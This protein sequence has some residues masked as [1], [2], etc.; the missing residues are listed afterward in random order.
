MAFV[1]VVF[2]ITVDKAVPLTV[3]ASASRVPST[4]T[5]FVTFKEPKVPTEVMFGCDAVCIVPVTLPVTFPCRLPSMLA[6][7]VALK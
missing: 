2:C 4:S 6:S 5:L 1:T 7:N 3:I